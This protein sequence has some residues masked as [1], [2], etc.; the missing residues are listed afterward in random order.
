MPSASISAGAAGIS[1][2]A[3]RT[4]WCASQDQGSLAGKGA[5]HVRR[6]AIMQMVEAALEGLAVQRDDPRS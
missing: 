2:G 6:G 5:Q 4:S 3:S 1:S